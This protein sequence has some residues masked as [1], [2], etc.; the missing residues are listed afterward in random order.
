MR[1][2]GLTPSAI[3]LPFVTVT[4]R[5]GET[6]GLVASL[7]DEKGG[8]DCK[9]PQ[10]KGRSL[11]P[12]F[13]TKKDP[14]LVNARHLKGRARLRIFRTKKGGSDCRSPFLKRNQ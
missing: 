1:V 8:S 4:K 11:L 14:P 9:L 12:V 6:E 7:Q 3:G 5:T 13:R 2:L 10:L